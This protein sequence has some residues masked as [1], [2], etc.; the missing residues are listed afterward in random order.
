VVVVVVVV[1]APV[2][3]RHLFEEE[4]RSFSILAPAV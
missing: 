2:M 1:V 4:G 3:M